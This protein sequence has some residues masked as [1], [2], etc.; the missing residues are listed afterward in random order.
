MSTQIIAVITIILVQVLPYIGIEIGSEELT[1]V[2]QTLWTIVAG[3]Y[4]WFQR[5]KLEKAP[6]G[7]G[8]VNILGVRK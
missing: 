6:L 1:Q 3:V 5:T 2:L 4:I 8:D 7:R